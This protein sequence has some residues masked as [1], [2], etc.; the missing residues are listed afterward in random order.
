MFDEENLISLATFLSFCL[1]V[2]NS[3]VHLLHYFFKKFS[4]FFR[5]IFT[6]VFREIFALFFHKIFAFF[7]EIFAI[8][9]SRTFRPFL[10]NR[11]KPKNSQF[12]R[13]KEMRKWSEMVAKDKIFR[14]MWNLLK[15]QNFLL[16]E[17]RQS[18]FKIICCWPFDK[19][20]T[21]RAFNTVK[22]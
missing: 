14:K 12:S 16:P 7:S 17:S 15:G 1:S 5:E 18:L 4:H 8:S 3:Y 9:I 11:L 21:W 10:R 2:H 20:K 6:L 19:L 22:S 13:A